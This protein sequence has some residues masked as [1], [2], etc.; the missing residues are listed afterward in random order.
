MDVIEFRSATIERSACDKITVALFNGVATPECV[1]VL[2]C[3]LDAALALHREL[4]SALDTGTSD[5]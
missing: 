3:D 1:A 4:G 5:A 2:N